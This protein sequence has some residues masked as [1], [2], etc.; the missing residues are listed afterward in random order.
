MERVLRVNDEFSIKIARLTA[1]GKMFLDE[2]KPY[3]ETYPADRQKLV[4]WVQIE[5]EMYINE[6]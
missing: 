2:M 1:K 6:E 5:K 4:A 3:E